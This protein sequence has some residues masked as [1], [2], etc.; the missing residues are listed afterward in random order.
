[1]KT[2]LLGLFLPLLEKEIPAREAAGLDTIPLRTYLGHCFTS[3]GSLHPAGAFGYAER[4]GLMMAALD[5]APLRARILDAGCGYGTESLLFSLS[6]RE[7]WG[8]ELV[9]ER[10]AFARSRV[11]Y[12]QNAA[13]RPLDL[14]F[15]NAHILR[16]LETGPS[17]D[18]I[19]AMESIS[20]IYP[21]ERFFSLCHDRL[22]ED[23]LLV[24]SDPNPMNPLALLRSIRIRGS[25]RHHPHRRFSDPETGEPTDYGQEQIVTLSRLRRSLRAAGFEPGPAEITGFMGSSFLPESVLASP[26]ASRYLIHF[27]EAM[28]QIP[29][30]RLFGSVYTVVARKRPR[31]KPRT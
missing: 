18:L 7:V 31:G 12:F 19:W 15:V 16:F 4:L 22:S 30:L 6:G 21:P 2:D 14:R 11:T 25:V 8:V 26:S 10:A 24:V 13:G 23:G 29:V 5:A 28:K 20:H 3:S 17:F 9:V 1:M 27:Q